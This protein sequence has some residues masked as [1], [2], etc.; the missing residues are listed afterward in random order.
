MTNLPDIGDIIGYK[1]YSGHV[2]VT[3]T[4]K[5][6]F[7]TFVTSLNDPGSDPLIIWYNGGPGCSSIKGWIQENGPKITEDGDLNW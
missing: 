3:D 7:Y 4:S 2:N 5:Q 1:L 6:L